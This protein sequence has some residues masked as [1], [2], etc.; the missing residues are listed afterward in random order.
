MKMNEKYNY[1]CTITKT[2]KHYF[3]K[4]NEGNICKYCGMKKYKKI[5]YD[6]LFT[7]NNKLC[8]NYTF[9]EDTHLKVLCI[10]DKNHSSLHT[11]GIYEWKEYMDIGDEK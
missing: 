11:N 9:T 5:D 1:G 10:K 8:M 7:S 2:K 3:I 6:A 4:T